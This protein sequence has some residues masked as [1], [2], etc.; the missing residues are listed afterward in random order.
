MPSVPPPS[1][2]SLLAAGWEEL[3]PLR[4]ARLDLALG[5]AAPGAACLDAGCATGS[6]PRALAAQGRVAHGLDLD[7]TFLGIARQRARDQGL[8][9]TWHE[10]SLLDLAAAVAGA[11]FQLI[12]CLGQTLPHLLEDA[13]WLS[14]FTQ[15][16]EVL[17]PGGRLVIQAVHDG[18]LPAGH[19]RDLPLLRCAEGTLERRRTMLSS[20]LACFET[21]FHP[22]AGTAVTSRATHR[23]MS[24]EVAAAMVQQAGFRPAP[25]L[26]DE[27]GTPFRDASAGW[28]LVAQRDQ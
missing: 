8:A 20:S 16:R 14:F 27:A 18:Q 28:I 23:R 1:P 25:P 15:A 22:L 17:A 5:L 11:R 13:Q 19:T 4:Q 10:A 2:W 12:T 24:P 7:P 21:V 26:A 6:L 9:V 3:F